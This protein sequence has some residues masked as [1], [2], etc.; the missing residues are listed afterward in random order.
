MGKYIILS[1]EYQILSDISIDISP[2]S[3]EITQRDNVRLI[4]VFLQEKVIFVYFRVQMAF[5]AKCGSE[6]ITGIEMVS[7]PSV[8]HTMNI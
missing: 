5:M 6:C 2:L 8:P 4:T 7:Q 1:D 3:T